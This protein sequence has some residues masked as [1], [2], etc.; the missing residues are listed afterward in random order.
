MYLK[1]RIYITIF[2]LFIM[3]AIF[4]LFVSNGQYFISKVF[5]FA[6][7]NTIDGTNKYAWSENLGWINFGT[8]QGDVSVTASQLTGYAWSENAGWIS[9]N[10]SNDSSC[11][12]VSYKVSNDGNG[13]L[14]GYAW[15]ENVG[16]INFNPAYGGVTVDV[17]TGEFSGYA[18]GENTGWIVFDCTTSACVDW[19]PRIS[20][21]SLPI[22]QEIYNPIST[23]TSPVTVPSA[24][25]SPITTPSVVA[26]QY[27]LDGL[28]ATLH[29]LQAQLVA[30]QGS[31]APSSSITFNKDFRL[32]DVNGDIKAL[33]QY[34]NALSF[35]VA[36]KGPGSPGNE[37]NFFGPLT[38]AALIKFQEA[39]AKEI[40]TPL[41]LTKG[42]GF[43]GPSTRNYI[44]S[45]K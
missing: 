19:Q 17:S 29:S 40:L 8:T 42:T 38:T 28:L 10:C 4:S 41:G 5:A 15:G 31:Y 18:W 12:T 24:S 37:T 1:K 35:T 6:A 39:H 27:Q 43:F 30:Q 22:L 36:G 23:S 44:N 2:P 9:L 21:L 34:L 25:S 45:L 26:L 16:W 3:V 13:V 14:S 11:G 33:Q 7:Q 20:G 32:G